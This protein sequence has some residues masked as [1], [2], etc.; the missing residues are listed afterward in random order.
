MTQLA[1]E[2]R[3]LP[4]RQVCLRY[5][6]CNRTLSR[7]DRNPELNFPKPIIINHRKYRDEAE[8]EAWDRAQATKSRLA[9]GSTTLPETQPPADTKRCNQDPSRSTAGSITVTDYAAVGDTIS[10]NRRKAVKAA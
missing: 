8:L 3:K 6:V 10:T 1:I 5:G 9:L 2:G 7:W 4:D